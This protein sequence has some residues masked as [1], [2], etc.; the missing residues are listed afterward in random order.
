MP[1]QSTAEVKLPLIA[2]LSTAASAFRNRNI[3][4]RYNSPL[5][6][7]KDA[8]IKRKTEEE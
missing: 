2:Y 5:K 6:D 7:I 4:L 3:R 1:V 8:H